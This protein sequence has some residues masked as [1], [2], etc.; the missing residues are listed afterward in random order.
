M[1]NVHMVHWKTVHPTIPLVK[2]LTQLF[3]RFQLCVW[4]YC[5]GICIHIVVLIVMLQSNMPSCYRGIR[6][7]AMECTYY[8]NEFCLVAMEFVDLRFR[9]ADM[10]P[11]VYAVGLFTSACY[12]CMHPKHMYAAVISPPIRSRILRYC[13][14][15][16][17][18]S[19][20]A[21]MTI[22]TICTIDS[23]EK[24]R[25]STAH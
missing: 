16:I 24:S 13:S 7:V 3:P 2:P 17:T 1:L 21:N 15:W 5:T 22:A 19:V 14:H 20:C 25:K 8:Y 18:Q 4:S 12:T 9:G 23:C 10:V 6:H 11:N